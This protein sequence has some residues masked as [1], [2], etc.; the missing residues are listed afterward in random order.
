M[1]FSIS[2]G[3]WGGFYW[4][5]D[6]TTR[7]CLGWVAFTFFPFDIDEYLE[8]QRHMRLGLADTITHS[9]RVSS[10]G[11]EHDPAQLEET[12]WDVSG[13]C[14]RCLRQLNMLSPGV[15]IIAGHDA[16]CASCLRPGET[17]IARA[18]GLF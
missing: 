7:L 12:R 15:S 2:I 14:P 5:H 11:S 8:K 17:E 1:T 18:K 6:F 16:V 3:R 10:N 9:A 13:T 4:H